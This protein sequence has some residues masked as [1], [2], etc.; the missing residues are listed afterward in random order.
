MKRSPVVLAVA[1]LAAATYAETPSQL[2]KGQMPDLGRPTKGDDQAPPFGDYFQ[3]LP[4]ILSEFSG[5][6]IATA[7]FAARVAAVS[8]RTS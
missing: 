4:A 1:L 7:D 8:A 6:R 3:A 5:G 2:P